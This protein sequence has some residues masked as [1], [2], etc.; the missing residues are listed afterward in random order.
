[1][2][3][4][5]KL[6]LEGV[7]QTEYHRLFDHYYQQYI[8]EFGLD[9]INE[10]ND[11]GTLRMLIAYQ[12]LIELYQRKLAELTETDLIA[13]AQET[14]KISDLLR[15][16][17]ATFQSLQH[18]LGI[19]RRTRKSNE[20]QSVSDYLTDLLHHANYFY[21]QQ[22]QRLYCPT[23]N[24]MVG[25]FAPVHEHTPYDVAFW[26]ETCQTWVDKVYAGSD[27][28]A[29]IPE[30]DREWRKAYQASIVLPTTQKHA[31]S[32]LPI[33]QSDEENEESVNEE[34][35]NKENIND[36]IDDDFISFSEAE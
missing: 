32:L 15:D 33:A 16:F 21:E 30:H 22:L 1:M 3:K 34:G 25:R 2:R 13:N 28:F 7:D 24:T 8:N 17:T 36:I 26:C 27:R 9:Q 18:A 10:A 12:V 31:M 6:N 35:I 5:S 14:K 29:D 11:A 23:C 4:Q 19:D 20:E